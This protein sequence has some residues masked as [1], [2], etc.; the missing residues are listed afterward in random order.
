MKKK[1]SKIYLVIIVVLAG[2]IGFYIKYFYNTAISRNPSDWGNF[3]GYIGGMLSII[4]V[5]LIY[6]TYKSQSEMNY[7]NQFE[8]ILFKML[9]RQREIYNA[10]SEIDLF[11]Q[12]R[13]EIACHFNSSSDFSKEDTEKLFV[14][15]YGYHI[16][17]KRECLHYFRHLY[18]IIKY[19]HLD[20]IIKDSDKKKYIDMI[21]SEMNDD[22]LFISLFNAV[23][24]CAKHKKSDNDDY[25]KWLDDYSFFENLQSP[26][27][28]FDKCKSQLFPKTKWKHFSPK[29]DYKNIDFGMNNY[30]KEVWYD[31]LE[32]LK[33][34]GY[35]TRK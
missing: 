5:F 22:E 23:W 9:D 18:H 16:S 28:W 21:Q 27:C 13:N 33:K 19:I 35:D 3:G 6:Y 14:W 29:T 2:T 20:K 1:D 15:Y 26:G 34:E 8:T 12:L 7:R 25:L 31:T 17:G 4:S 30:S 10:I 32:R 11:C 24:W